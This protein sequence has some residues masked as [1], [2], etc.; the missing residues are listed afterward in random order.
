[1]DNNC[2]LVINWDGS[3]NPCCWDYLGEY[4]FGN[5]KD[6]G[7][8]SVWN[9]TS[10]QQHRESIKGNK[11]LEICIDCANSKTVSIISLTDKGGEDVKKS[12]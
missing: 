10:Y 8:Y 9:D 4:N 11:F 7:V 12:I 5:V 2:V 6:R 3:V 1:M